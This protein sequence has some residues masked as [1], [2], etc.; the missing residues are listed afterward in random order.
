MDTLHKLMA[1]KKKDKPLSDTAKEAKMSVV[2]D[3]Q[4][5]AAD[6]MR[7]G[8]KGGLKKVSVASDS[9]EGLKKGLEKAEELVESGLTG[10]EEME[11]KE[12][13][14]ELAEAEEE[15]PSVTPEGEENL[16]EE[17]SEEE[18]DAKLAKLME[19]KKKLQAKK[20]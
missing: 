11:E 9:P 4:K 13:G 17:C 19:L 8:L 3:M 20:A 15:V 7:D 6:A 10:E 1:K 5:M 2:K 14:E 12:P 18:L 16:D